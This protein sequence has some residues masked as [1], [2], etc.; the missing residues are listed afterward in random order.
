MPA[1]RW[2]LLWEGRRAADRNE[3]F[4]LF[5]KTGGGTTRGAG[6]AIEHNDS[7][8]A[9]FNAPALQTPATEVQTGTPPAS[10]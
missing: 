5:R 4:R 1:G 6:D 9:P 10:Q 2:K 8:D 3:R 7:R